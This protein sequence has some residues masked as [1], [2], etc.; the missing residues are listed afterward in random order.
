MSSNISDA[1]FQ[2]LACGALETF[3]SS[4][5]ATLSA[6]TFGSS[7]VYVPVI[8]AM[9]NHRGRAGIQHRGT[10]LLFHINAESPQ[11]KWPIVNAGGAEAILNA[12]KV[13]SNN[14]GVLQWGMLALWGLGV[15]EPIIRDKIASMGMLKV[16]TSAL[17]TF[18]SDPLFQA[19][20]LTSLIDYANDPNHCKEVGDLGAAELAVSAARVHPEEDLQQQAITVL[21]NLSVHEQSCR[22]RIRQ[23]G[24][25]ETISAAMQA[26]PKNEKLQI[27]G[28]RALSYLWTDLRPVASDWK[29]QRIQNIDD[30]VK[31]VKFHPG[32]IVDVLR[33]VN[34]LIEAPPAENT[35]EIFVGTAEQI[36]DM[37]KWNLERKSQHQAARD[38]AKQLGCFELAATAMRSKN[39]D[40]VNQILGCMVAR[41]LIE[42]DADR[43]KVRSLGI[44]DLVLAGMKNYPEDVML[45]TESRKFLEVYAP[46]RKNRN[47][48]F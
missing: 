32:I 7:G 2:E 23:I 10:K 28:C 1:D 48:L 17:R 8:N 45:Q 21:L 18:P 20:G 19:D 44:A 33:A 42:T 31:S 46:N 16:V 14:V 15:Q 26:F 3:R 41:K 34:S 24:G 30:V 36:A 9:K 47:I 6:E 27:I 39:G 12:M 13:H 38:L 4:M 35:E 37:K 29:S 22:E 5:D 25:I 11:L 40:I 43:A